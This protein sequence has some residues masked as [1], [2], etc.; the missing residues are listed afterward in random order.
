M[1]RMLKNLAVIPTALVLIVATLWF[2]FDYES[3][4]FEKRA[5]PDFSSIENIQEKKDTFFAFML[6]IIRRANDA[7][8][9]ERQLVYRFKQHVE[10][11]GNLAQGEGE[12]LLELAR[13]YR[14]KGGQNS[15]ETKIRLLLERI[16]T[17]PA[18]LALAQ[19]ANESA[20]GTAR[21]AREGNNYFGLWCWSRN[22]GMIPTERD[23]VAVHE[24]ASFETAEAGV[25]HYMQTLNSHPAY[26]LLRDLRTALKA[27]GK[28]V[29][30]WD[31][32]GGL[33]D[34]SER[35]EAYVDEIREMITYNDLHRFTRIKYDH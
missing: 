19:A 18:S 11:G 35:R 33:L 31:L 28:T 32:A 17:I 25:A 6:P 2:V 29:N 4:S 16:D 23:K 13:K 15:E 26:Q 20:W 24:V 1:N 14:I 9:K 27:N 10:S 12:H 8:R 22:C 3:D 30:G 34:Y 7:I 5:V 21:F